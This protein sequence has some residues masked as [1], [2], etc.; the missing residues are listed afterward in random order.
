MKEAHGNLTLFPCLYCPFKTKR[1]HDLGGHVKRIHSRNIDISF[2][3][4]I[5][6]LSDVF[7]NVGLGGVNNLNVDGS[8]K[9]DVNLTVDTIEDG[10][11]CK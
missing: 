5:E 2:S 9:A 4:L 6:I 10:L 1:R 11:V 8:S 7:A 3:L